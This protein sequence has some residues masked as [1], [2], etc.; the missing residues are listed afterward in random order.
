MSQ[1]K[2]ETATELATDA[3]NLV[4]VRSES[5]KLLL[6]NG[7]LDSPMC[8]RLLKEVEAQGWTPG[9][10]QIRI[11]LDGK[12]FLLVAQSSVKTNPVQVARQLGLDAASALAKSKSKD[13]CIADTDNLKALDVLEGFL[14]GQDDGAAF[15]SKSNT[16]YPKKL[17][18][19]SK[20]PSEL[21][22]RLE[23]AKSLV[24]TRWLQDAPSNFINPDQFA[25]IAKD[26]FEKSAELVVLGRK[27]M[28]QLGMGSFLS[29]AHGAHTEPRLVALKI[30]GKNPAKTVALV[31]KGVTFDAGGINIKPSA[32]LEEMKFDMSGAAAVLGAA[33]YFTAVQPP[34][35]VVCALGAVENMLGPQATKPGDV[36]TAFNGKTIEILN[37]DAEGRLVLADVLS[38]ICDKFKPELVLD[39]ATLTG[40]VIMG[41]GHVGA[42]IM[43]KEQKTADF[44]KKVSERVG[45]PLWQLPL[46]P[47]LESEVNSQLADLKN[48]AKPSVKAGPIMGGLFLREFVKDSNC[49]WAHIDIAGTAWTCGATGYHTNGGSAFGVRALVGAAEMFLS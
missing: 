36:V 25:T 1:L 23:M 34:V 6:N 41:L 5:D 3:W 15:K 17:S 11:Q 47:E 12:K 38:Y 46:W 14:I 28:E 2:I 48:I 45:E 21:T 31:G 33:M 4:A 10:K 13:L 49:E 27:E 22:K 44:L 37:T 30:A 16:E 29:V 42:G 20:D 7:L 18:V 9:E 19:V 8:E 32:G 26:L 40:A 43:V 24:F 39:I 35:N